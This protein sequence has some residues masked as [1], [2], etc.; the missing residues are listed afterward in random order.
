MGWG[1]RATAALA[2]ALVAVAVGCGGEAD[3]ALEVTSAPSATTAP[4]SPTSTVPVVTA[5]APV[6]GPAVT[7]GEDVDAARAVLQR[8]VDAFVAADG[9]TACGL[10]TDESAEAFLQAVGATVGASSCAEAFTAVTEQLPEEQ[11]DA[12]RSAVIDDLVVTGDTARG[13]LTVIGVSNE[14]RLTRVLGD[15]RIANLPGN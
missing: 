13:R 14:F 11:R 7:T 3:D 9:A 10:L 5:P 2:A 4:A 6:T 8:Y 12:F 1:R 15:W